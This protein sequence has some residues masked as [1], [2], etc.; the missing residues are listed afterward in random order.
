MIGVIVFF[1]GVQLL[2][3]GIIGQ[4]LG[5]VFDEVKQRPIYI[6]EQKAGFLGEIKRK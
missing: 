5:R 1:G 2:M 6:S 3:L 4:Y